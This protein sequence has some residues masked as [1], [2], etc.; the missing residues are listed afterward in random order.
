MPAALRQG[1]ALD[2]ADAETW[3]ARSQLSYI[4]YAY[5]HDRS[6]AR[7][8]LEGSDAERAIA[9]APNGYEPRLAQAF[10]Y[11]KQTERQSEAERIFNSLRTENPHDKRVL[12]NLG[13]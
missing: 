1:R 2:P 9:L 12:R 4:M 3:A 11:S 8:K 5:F 7:L 13:T 6:E 10:A